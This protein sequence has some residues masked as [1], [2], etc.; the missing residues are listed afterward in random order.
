MEIR[1]LERIANNI[2]K[3]YGPLVNIEV[4]ATTY[5]ITLTSPADIWEKIADTY[6]LTKVD[7]KT[8]M[9]EVAGEY[10]IAYSW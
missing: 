6:H 3:K 4:S 2:S 10:I 1:K 9:G 8:A 5:D 7:N